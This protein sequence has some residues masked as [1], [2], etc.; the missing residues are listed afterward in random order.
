MLP[1]SLGHE[2]VGKAVGKTFTHDQVRP[3]Q[4]MS[5]LPVMPNLMKKHVTERNL[6]QHGNT[7]Q[8]AIQYAADRVH[9]KVDVCRLIS[10]PRMVGPQNTLFLICSPIRVAQVAVSHPR[11]A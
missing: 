6:S 9:A 11:V 3:D 7:D 10:A 5:Q 4:V 8:H 2:L 1:R